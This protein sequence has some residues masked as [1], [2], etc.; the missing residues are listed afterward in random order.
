MKKTTI[1]SLIVVSVLFFSY[2]LLV[3]HYKVFPY[4]L[5]NS[6]KPDDNK[7]VTQHGSSETYGTDVDSLIHIHNESDIQIKRDA[8]I[9][10]VWSEK[11]F[12]SE[13]IPADVQKTISDP[14]YADIGDLQSIDKITVSMDH[15]VESIAYLFHPNKSQNILVIY[16]QGHDGDFIKGK[17]TIRFLLNKGY[18]V[19]AFSM[20]L[21][22]MNNQPVI[23]TQFGRIKMIDHDQFQL[24]ESSDLSPIKYFV[25]PVAVSLNYLDKEYD[26]DS[27]YMVGLS[28]GGWTTTLYSAIDPRISQSYSVAGSVPI[29]LR[30]TQEN[31]GDYEQILP[32]LYKN[33]D[34]LDLYIL[35]SYGG[36]RKHVQIFN[37]YDPCCFGG[38]AYETY[39]DKIKMTLS[40]LGK[41]RFDA[42]LDD[43]HKEHKISERSLDF[44]YNS[45]KS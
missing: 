36:E 3:G 15:D 7:F 28:G 41:G 17:D 35:A 45:M 19:L 21:L 18:S 14:R 38:L 44:I 13:K 20:P 34:Y 25:E 43:S 31:L 1:V 26:F 5:L 37:K 22:G 33:A 40:D 24:I 9:N 16:H 29:Y 2:G 10:Y 27:Y 12:P 42:Y 32:A 6:I 39:A 30:S 23:D 11:E 4:D 8:V